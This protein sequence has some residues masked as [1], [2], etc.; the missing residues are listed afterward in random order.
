MARA[1][2]L[3]EHLILGL[4]DRLA[5]RGTGRIDLQLDDDPQRSLAGGLGD[6][7]VDGGWNRLSGRRPSP[8]QQGDSEQ[9]CKT[10]RKANVRG[11][12]P[13]TLTVL[14][15]PP[16]RS[17]GAW[18]RF[19]VE[20]CHH[21]WRS[22]LLRR[23]GAVKFSPAGGGLL[24]AHRLPFNGS[25]PLDGVARLEPAGLRWRPRDRAPRL[26]IGSSRVVTLRS[27]LLVITTRYQGRSNGLV[28]RTP[29]WVLGRQ[30]RIQRPDYGRGR[31]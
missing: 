12:Q 22:T 1:G 20:Y 23:R 26:M 4:R 17:R 7:V 13:V 18:T 15:S 30:G 19:Q 29:G 24:T 21:A 2:Q 14:P 28:A 10:K 16:E 5:G 6:Q 11:P 27:P 9:E 8:R 31:S 25:G 3:L